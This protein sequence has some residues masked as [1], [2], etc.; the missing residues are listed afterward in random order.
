VTRFAVDFVTQDFTIRTDKAARELGYE[1]LYPPEEAIE[2]TVAYYA[3][4]RR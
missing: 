1:P 2:R 3:S 4:K